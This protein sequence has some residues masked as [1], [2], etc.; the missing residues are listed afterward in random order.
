MQTTIVKVLELARSPISAQ[1]TVSELVS[2][3]GWLAR[4]LHLSLAQDHQV[5]S[6]RRVIFVL[7]PEGK[8]DMVGLFRTTVNEW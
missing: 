6:R 2:L 3:F 8:D 4:S 1:G 7:K 5:I